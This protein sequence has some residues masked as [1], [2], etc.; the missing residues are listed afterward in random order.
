[1]VEKE[2]GETELF[3]VEAESGAVEHIAT[4]PEPRYI[5]KCGWDD[6][7]FYF[8]P[9]GWRWEPFDPPIIE[10]NRST[11]QETVIAKDRGYHQMPSPDGRSIVGLRDGT[12][13][14]RPTSG[15]D[16]VPLVS[17]I[18]LNH[19]VFVTPDGKW[20]VYQGIV[21]VSKIG[22]FRV[23]ITGGEPQLMGGPP[24]NI[25][26]IRDLIFSPDGRHVL[27]WQVEGTIDLW[28]LEDFEPPEKK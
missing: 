25:Y 7:T 9:N 21:D 13:S 22:L 4:F 18:G 11:G 12:L 1:M 23:P 26:L 19:P 16:W 6:Q 5:L 14:V 2:K 3:S 8:S 10:W 15:G 17:G 24:S 20:A 28:L 27:I